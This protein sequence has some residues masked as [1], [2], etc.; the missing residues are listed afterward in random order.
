VIYTIYCVTSPNQ[1]RYIGQTVDFDRRKYAHNAGY[2]NMVIS[3]AIKKHGSDNML[4]ETLCICNTQKDA[5]IAEKF[6]IAMFNTF[7]G[8]GYNCAEGGQGAG[9]GKTNHQY[10]C[11]VNDDD[12]VRLKKEGS[13]LKDISSTVGLSV[14]QVRRR[15]KRLGLKQDRAGRAGKLHKSY[16]HDL[17][18]DEMIGMREKGYSYRRIGREL[19]CHYLTV[20]KRL[21]ETVINEMMSL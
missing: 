6:Y 19:G 16:R 12:I 2:S 17:C 3:K 14:A 20:I 7:I 13:T 10:K 18:I 4:W 8:R 11:C 5:D 15:L 9:T 21:R 1:K